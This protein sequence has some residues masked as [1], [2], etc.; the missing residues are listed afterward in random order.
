MGFP[1]GVPELEEELGFSSHSTLYHHLS[2]AMFKVML[3]GS[4]GSSHSSQNSLRL[5]DFTRKYGK[6]RCL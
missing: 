6:P 4:M 3:Q 1:T 2:K 5:P